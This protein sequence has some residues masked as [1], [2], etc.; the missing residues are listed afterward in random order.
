MVLNTVFSKKKK[1]VPFHKYIYKW[2]A[3]ICG[4]KITPKTFS[5][6]GKYLFLQLKHVFGPRYIMIFGHFQG[7][8]G[9]FNPNM[10]DGKVASIFL[11]P[12][13]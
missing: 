6:F 13:I 5:P 4:K 8:E 3:Q 12:L 10:R 7:Y 9:N 11:V 2:G 1:L